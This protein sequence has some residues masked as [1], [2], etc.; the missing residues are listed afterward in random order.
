MGNR[1]R[2]ASLFGAALVLM[3]LAL[4]PVGGNAATTT[5]RQ[6]IFAQDV[7]RLGLERNVVL[8]GPLR[9][10][11]LAWFWPMSTDAGRKRQS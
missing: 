3:A 1:L 9:D 2:K 7:Q 6:Q 8:T 5:E 11:E 10:E 4:Q